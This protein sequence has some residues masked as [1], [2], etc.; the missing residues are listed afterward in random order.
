VLEE[1]RCERAP[2]DLQMSGDVGED[3]ARCPRSE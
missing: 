3:P 1:R 2:L